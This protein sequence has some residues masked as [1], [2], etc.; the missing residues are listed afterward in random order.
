M[1]TF[2]RTVRPLS[3]GEIEVPSPLAVVTA[4][5]VGQ[6]RAEDRLGGM[7][8][9][10]WG[11]LKL[12]DTDVRELLAT[13]RYFRQRGIIFDITHLN[14]PGSGQDPNGTGSS[15]VQ[16]AGGSQSG[17][18]LDTDGWPASTSNV[19]M[20]GDVISVAGINQVLEIREATNSDGGGAATLTINPPILA[21]SEPA[22]NATVTTTGVLLRA[23]IES[24]TMPSA[25]PAASPT[26]GWLKGLEITFRLMP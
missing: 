5:G 23:R 25:S 16:V 24:S 12:I 4:R 2:P 8:T 13:I 19:V 22:D 26:E 9:E 11:A 17:E 3:P 1:A 7:W 20:P 10:R 18:T 15:G 21:G 6:V 14:M